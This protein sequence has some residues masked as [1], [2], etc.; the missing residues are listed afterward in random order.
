MNRSQSKIRHIQEANILLEKRLL[1]EQVAVNTWLTFPGDKNYQY[2]KQNNKWVAKIIKT[3]KVIDLS[4]YPSTVQKLETQFPGGKSPAGGT[5]P[6]S[7][8]AT[9][10][11][12]VVKNETLPGAPVYYPWIQDG[13]LNTEKLKQSIENKSIYTWGQELNKLTPEQLVKVRED[14][15][16]SG[17]PANLTTTKGTGLELAVNDV[18]NTAD[19]MVAQKNINGN[20]QQ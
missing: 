20:T 17:I 10:N 19:K 18:L 3:G 6:V 7:S 4:K 9:T 1:N 16:T 5:T 14:F 12:V 15:K 8:T 2:Q 11:N 13:K